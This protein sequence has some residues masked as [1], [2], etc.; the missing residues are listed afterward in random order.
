[1]KPLTKQE[2]EYLP[3]T[4]RRKRPRQ[5]PHSERLEAERRYVR[6]VRRQELKRRLRRESE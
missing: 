4:H 6:R 3:Y 1:M 2:A 5:H